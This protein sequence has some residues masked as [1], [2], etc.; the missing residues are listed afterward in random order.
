MIIDLYFT[1]THVDQ[2]HCSQGTDRIED[3]YERM[4][5]LCVRN[6]V[7]DT[8]NV[9]ILRW[10][11]ENMWSESNT[12]SVAGDLKDVTHKPTTA[13]FHVIA[14]IDVETPPRTSLN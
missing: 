3:N 7:D 12:W 1:E 13:R 14:D 9:R 11:R 5:V 8:V 2:Y 4:L 10:C 6:L